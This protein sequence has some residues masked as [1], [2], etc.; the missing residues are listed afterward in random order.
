MSSIADDQGSRLQHQFCF[1][2]TVLRTLDFTG[3]NLTA[4]N[5][6]RADARDSVFVRVNFHDADMTGIDL[7]GADLTGAKNLTIEQLQSAVID[8]HTKL[9]DYTD[10]SR[11]TLAPAG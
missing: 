1:E 8:E 3:V 11:L 6:R 5:L 4:A 9:P 10:R 2:G 7:R